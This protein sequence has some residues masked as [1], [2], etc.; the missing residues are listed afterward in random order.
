[1]GSESGLK[2]KGVCGR[3][4]FRRKYERERR[5]RNFGTMLGLLIAVGDF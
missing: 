2:G 5:C 4:G 1:M 3:T